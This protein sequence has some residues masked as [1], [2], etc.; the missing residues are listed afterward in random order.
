MST[1]MKDGLDYILQAINNLI[2]PK[3]DKLRYDRTYRAKVTAI[4]G[5]GLYEVQIKNT[6][7]NVSYSGVLSIGDVVKVKA[8]LNNFSDIYI[9]GTQSGGGGD[10]TV[11]DTLPIGAVVEWYANNIPNNWLVCNGQAVSRE[12]YSE[13]FG[14]IG[15]QYGSGDGSTTFNLP[16]LKGRVPVGL[17]PDD[18]DFNSLGEIGGQKSEDLRATVGATHG[19]TTRI[20]YV[21]AA[22][23]PNINYSYSV[24]GSDASSNIPASAVS[25][26]TLVLTQD[27][28]NPSSLQPYLVSYFIIKAKQI[29]PIIATVIN[30]LNS[31]S[32]IDALA[33][34]QGKILNDKITNVN[35][36]STEETN[37]GK[38]WIDGKDIYRKVYTGSC[39]ANDSQII[40]SNLT[41]INMPINIYGM[42]IRKTDKLASPIGSF[43]AINQGDSRVFYHGGNKTLVIEKDKNIW[44]EN[45]DYIVTIEYTKTN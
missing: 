11:S 41:T 8:P 37:T 31:E 42:F 12:N 35:T 23:I 24:L 22:K 10:Y 34:N 6:K 20:G 15:T 38:K 33:A 26:S 36:Y 5:G 2:E 40:A 44:N 30:N 28:K 7:Y 18:T 39:D 16:N 21:A 19:A 32:T 27:G 17:D 4:A 3:L 29:T 43:F 1:S 9:E 13:L 14:I 45:F 25:H